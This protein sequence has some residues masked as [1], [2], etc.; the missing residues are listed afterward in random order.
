MFLK[1]LEI[2]GFKSFAERIA[3]DFVPGVTAVV[4]PNGSGK[5]NITDAIR[6]VLGEQSA[7][8][9]RGSK[10]EDVIF[11]GSDS[12]KSL[13]F[14]E[15]TLILDNS[16]GLFPL[17]YTEVSVSR[18][19]F[20]SGESAYLLN[21]QQ[22][23]LKDINDVFMDSG[24]GKEA[25]S[26]ISQGRVD[27]ILNS[28]PEDRRSI[29][30]EA[31]GVLKYR[32][33][34]KKAEHKLFETEDN[35][36]RVLDILKELESRIEPLRNSAEAAK[37]HK[38]LSEETRE[39]DVS[40]L[41]FDAGNLRNEILKRSQEAEKFQEK[42]ILLEAESRKA[43]EA[44]EFA[45][46]ELAKMDEQLDALQKKLVVTSAE[47]EKWEGRR[48][49]SLEKRRNADQLI[50]RSRFEL[51]NTE[52]ELA[53]LSEKLGAAREK[54][55][56]SEIE[57][58]KTKVEMDGI[59]HI[60]KRSVKETEK[61]IDELKS[62][63]IDRL[64][65]EATIRNDLK[66]AE[67]RLQGEQSS[68]EKIILQ[69]S[70]LQER[71]EK[72]TQEKS[73]KANSLTVLKRK[74][75]ESDS[76]YRELSKALRK[77][78]DELASQQELM[79]KALNKQH[80]MHG[81]VRAL[82]SME[83]DFSGFYSGVK[84]I[85]VAKKSG[86]LAGIDGAVA[87]LISVEKEYIKAVETA[88]G[89][90]M[91]H[92]VTATE[93]E[94][95]KA[96]G[97]LKAKNA[98]RATF[99]PRDVM[100]SRKIQPAALRSVELHPEYIGTAD[101]LVQTDATYALITE[102]L[103]GNTIVAKTLVGASAI[104]GILGY[105]FRV[106][107]LDGDVVNAGGSLTGGGVKGQASVFTRKAELET[108]QLQ[109]T[110]MADSIESAT[111]KIGDTKMGVAKQIYE[112]DQLRKLTDS[113]QIEIAA[114][115]SG[116]RET[117]IAIKS[118]ESEI[119]STE[120]GRRGVENTGSELLE[121]KAALHQNHKRVKSE[122]EAI[123]SKVESLERLATNRRNEEATLT[124]RYNELRECIAVLREQKAHLQVTIDEMED[125]SAQAKV[126]L[127]ALRD[128]MQ[129]FT[130][131]ENGG[132]LSAEQIAMEI[133]RASA[134]KKLIEK[135]IMTDREIRTKLANL[136]EEKSAT[137]QK[138]RASTGETISALNAV[139]IVLSRLEV[140]YEAVTQ[141]LLTEYGLFADGIIA[142]DF[143]EVKTREKVE[144]LKRQLAV[145]GPVNPGAI[146]EFEEVSERHLFLDEQR[147][148]LLKAK[149]TLH[150][151]MSE[152]DAE[153]TTR[154]LTTFN[155]VQNR[156][157]HVFKEMF[158]GGEADLILTQPDNL[159]ETGVEIV[160]RPPGKKLQSLSLL[161]GGERA[162]TA[163][164]LLFSIIEVRPVPFC[165]L[166][167]VEAALDEANVI[168]YSKYLKKFS[169]KTQFIVITHRKGTMEGADVLY[170]I[171]MQ[172]SGVSR[173]ISVKISEVPEEAIM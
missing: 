172:E 171:T 146:V 58:E 20:R 3:I 140:K 79:Q 162:L 61:E 36:D 92:I 69:T 134:D 74:L 144:S 80:E 143:D 42:K 66:H 14:A 158:G 64:N 21:G 89:G 101:R 78:E 108:L 119:A 170:G 139:S 35:L 111:K 30:D 147:N 34:K 103:L 51:A 120:M 48:L 141:Q 65:E 85:L 167:E 39:A 90:A 10:M 93:P 8:S 43:E 77:T 161:S 122:L 107:T 136:L 115:E 127:T 40:L 163:I 160:A 60:L 75:K 84:E 86:K 87:E 110:R 55:Q 6:W 22:C 121:K 117:D 12:R 47:T 49:L 166:D 91:Q 4:G 15:V 32:T 76:A 130:G 82:E 17:D 150:E 45:K 23:R 2:M 165:I 28:R 31:A 138:L 125:A 109:L 19:V 26:M 135:S 18:R 5:S 33:R 29:F 53:T 67:E 105:R 106:V 83:A 131:N 37:K 1:R 95:R 137:L 164:S 133:E 72:L 173:V 96:I 13:N 154:F 68:S 132:E 126:K 97:Y 153:M 124:S 98:G 145:L 148:D 16:K 25:F 159:L 88:L 52:T 157:R 46:K 41:T 62:A 118:V 24:L 7:K 128:E 50:E 70:I 104:A 113:L 151:A 116:I 99:L 100:K 59:S 142:D 71:Y 114:A 54:Q 168:R 129:Y 27:E 149:T 73:V 9:L 44:S 155:A 38:V 63:Y 112:V 156:F 11:A 123:Q 57:Y 152:M 81:R 169:E 102:N 56:Q 94:A